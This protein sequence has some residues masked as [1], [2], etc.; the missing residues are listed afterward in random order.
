MDNFG[1]LLQLNKDGLTDFII[2]GS[3]YIQRIYSVCNKI[4]NFYNQLFKVIKNYLTF[5]YKQ[6]IIT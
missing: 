2:K 4:C 6:I 1:F 3:K 5:N